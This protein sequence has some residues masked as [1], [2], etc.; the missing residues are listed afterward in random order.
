MMITRNRSR[1]SASNGR[2]HDNKNAI[3]IN[4]KFLLG[5]W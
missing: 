3:G 4:G 2:K 1:E 5:I